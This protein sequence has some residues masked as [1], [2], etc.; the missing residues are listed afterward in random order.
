MSKIQNKA[1]F[2][3]HKVTPDVLSSDADVSYELTVTWPETKLDKPGQ[4]LGRD[5]TQPQPKLTLSPAVRIYM[6]MLF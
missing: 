4:E 3:E 6:P 1:L 2:S 5:Q